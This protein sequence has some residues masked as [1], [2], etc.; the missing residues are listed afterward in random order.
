MTTLKLSDLFMKH[1]RTFDGTVRLEDQNKLIE[2]LREHDVLKDQ[3]NE[4]LC[5]QECHGLL[6]YWWIEEML[7]PTITRLCAKHRI[8]VV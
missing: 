1:G 4:V 2:R 3:L 7:F 6:L 8:D 5:F